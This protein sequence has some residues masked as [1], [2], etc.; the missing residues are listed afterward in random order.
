MRTDAGVAADAQL[1]AQLV[2]FA[3]RLNST[4]LSVGKSG[5]LSARCSTGFLVTPSGVAYDA[6]TAADIV[7]CDA[8]G[9]AA[10]GA[11]RPSSEW[12]IHRD[13]YAARPEVAAIVHAH[14][15]HAGALACTRRGIPAFHYMVLAAGGNDI[16]CADYATFGT[17][18]LSAA[19]LAALEGR[20][21]CLM[22]NHGQLAVGATL[23][24]AFSLAMEVE[25]LAQQYVIAIQL[26]GPVLLA[27]DE[28][29]AVRVQFATAY[30]NRDE[31]APPAVG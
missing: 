14:S 7:A 20:R 24:Q 21:A 25:Q 8:R 28:M 6:L 26:G 22:A 9:V 12:R 29:D 27:D 18:A 15:T 16:R 4:G 23:A 17:G 11:L 31:D 19:V 1:R 13:I 10:D 5:N 2:D 3:R 30:G